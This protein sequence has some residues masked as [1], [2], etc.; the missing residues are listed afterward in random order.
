M[1]RIAPKPGMGAS[2]TAWCL[3]L[4]LV[5]LSHDVSMAASGHQL[6]GVTDAA[7]TSTSHSRA[8]HSGHSA[9]SGMPEEL[10]P[11]CDTIRVA[12]HLKRLGDFDPAPESTMPQPMP[13]VPADTRHPAKLDADWLVRNPHATRSLSQ[14]FR[15]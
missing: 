9:G 1:R 13:P 12:P 15:I 3:L 4:I 11:G 8:H 5:V 10:P 7:G 6:A 2:A 14:V